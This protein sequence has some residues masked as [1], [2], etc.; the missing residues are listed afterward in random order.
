M[1]MRFACSTLILLV[2]GCVSAHITS[3]RPSFAAASQISPRKYVAAR[4]PT[5]VLSLEVDEKLVAAD[6]TLIFAF[7]FSRTLSNILTS[8]DFPGWLAPIEVN[9]LR[10]ETTLFFAGQWALA[11]FVSGLLNDTF[12]PGVDDESTR[13][14]GVDGA[15]RCFGFAAA[16]IVASSLA[17]QS[18][19][20]EPPPL[21]LQLTI[22]NGFGALGIAIALVA[23]RG[24][25]GDLPRYW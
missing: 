22:D 12:A 6:V 19:S 16:L 20:G 10:L 4:A 18:V 2:D 13:R 25:L 17:V 11:W 21:A 5:P 8:P 3:P 14:I 23:W 1:A 15:L 9:P 7:C 24:V